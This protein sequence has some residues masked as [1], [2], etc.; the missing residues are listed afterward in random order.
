MSK[1]KFILLL[2]S[3]TDYC[4]VALA[5]EERGV[6]AEREENDRTKQSARLAVMANEV[7]A[8]IPEGAE[9]SAVCLAE[10]PGSY[11]GLRIAAGYAKGLAWSRNIPLLALPT[12]LLIAL[13]YKATE[14]PSTDALLM[15][16]IDARRMEVYS[17]LYTVNNEAETDI[18]TLIL[19]EEETQKSLQEIVGDRELVYFGSGAE[20]AQTLMGSL[21]PRSRFVPNIYPKAKD[22]AE[23]AFSLLEEG[24]RLDVAYW[25]PFYLKEYEAKKTLNKV[26][27][28]IYK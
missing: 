15:P 20:K 5:S 21:L 25:E 6:V 9:L 18:A 2:D 3:S 19:T 28:N 7:L 12:T 17:A 11:T 27:R 16:M 8:E 24:Q 22:M 23:A 10:G 26:L 1:D 14:A 4:S 13:S